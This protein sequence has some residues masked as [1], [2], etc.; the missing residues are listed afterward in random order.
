MKINL[1]QLDLLYSGHVELLEH[2][3]APRLIYKLV[4]NRKVMHT[5]IEN[6]QE[7]IEKVERDNEGKDRHEIVNLQN[8]AIQS[9]FK[10]EVE[11]DLKMI[12][13]SELPQEIKGTTVAKIEA[14]MTGE[15]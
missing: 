1:K 12:E 8:E 3:L 13:W 15:L 14:V 9:L 6:M 11:V 7:T 10:D 4:T 2:T 5:H